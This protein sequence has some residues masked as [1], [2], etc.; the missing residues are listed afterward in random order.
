M[1]YRPANSVCGKDALICCG[2]CT[3]D[4]IL[5][6]GDAM[7]TSAWSWFVVSGAG[8]RNA[9]A[10]LLCSFGKLGTFERDSDGYREAIS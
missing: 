4:Y 10:V 9:G 6:T 1:L 5:L 7:H 8:S 2:C 3:Y